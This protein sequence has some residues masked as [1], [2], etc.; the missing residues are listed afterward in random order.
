[1]SVTVD[2]SQPELLRGIG[3]DGIEYVIRPF[4]W[5]LDRALGYYE[6]FAAFG[7]I[8]DHVPKNMQGFI[9]TMVGSFSLWFEM[10]RTDSGE[11][12][13]FIYLTDMCPSLTEKRYLS[14]TIHA[15]TWDSKASPR[16]DLAKRFLV[17]L[18]R[19]FKFHRLQMVIPC[20]RGG[21][22]RMAKRLGFKDEGVM[23]SSV[24]YKGIWFNTL[25]LSLLEGE[26]ENGSRSA[27]ATNP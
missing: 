13:G 22:I 12:V 14:A 8:S 9:R 21:A 7:L 4:E 24:S 10:V 6:R 2:Q 23:R 1:M 5:S 16:L 15:V 20:N 26:V 3:K 18:F 17:N 27:E 25:L 11:N 19:M